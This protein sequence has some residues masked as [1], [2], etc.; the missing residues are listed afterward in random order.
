MNE[1]K[2]DG[3]DSTYRDYMRCWCRGERAGINFDLPTEAQWEY[4][5]RVPKSPSLTDDDNFNNDEVPYEVTPAYPDRNLGMKFEE[6]ISEEGKDA[7]LDLIAW[8]KYKV[9]GTL[10]EP[11]RYCAWRISKMMFGICK[12]KE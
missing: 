11:E 3:R 4:C 10:P 5:C 9:I 7:G 8:Y 1:P 12:D 6:R 2:M